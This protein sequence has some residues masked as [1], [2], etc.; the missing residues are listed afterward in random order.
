METFH[1]LTKD[2]IASFI[3]SVYTCTVYH[4]KEGSSGGIKSREMEI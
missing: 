2:N 3:Y 4:S 1:L